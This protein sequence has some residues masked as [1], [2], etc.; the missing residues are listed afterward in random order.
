MKS[1]KFICYPKINTCAFAVIYQHAQSGKNLHCLIHTFPI[2][3]KQGSALPSCFSSNICTGR[4]FALIAYCWWF[5]F[6]MAP[7][8]SAEVHLV[9]IMSPC[10]PRG[11]L[12]HQGTGHVHTSCVAILDK[13]WGGE[14]SRSH[15]L[16]WMRVICWRRLADDWPQGYASRID[17]FP[18]GVA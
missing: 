8:C 4:F 10:W 18:R 17:L 16:H 7:K 6:K 14:D 12:M 3:V 15:R 1:L 5:L 13:I 2:E 11:Q 9:F